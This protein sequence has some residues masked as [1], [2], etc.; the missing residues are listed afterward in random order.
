MKKQVLIM[1][2]KDNVGIA[3]REIGQGESI[4]GE[5]GGED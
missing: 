5:D 1:D 4:H 3:V 2:P